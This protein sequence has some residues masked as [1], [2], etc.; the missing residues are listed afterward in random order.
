MFFIDALQQNMYLQRYFQCS[1]FAVLGLKTLHLPS[2]YRTFDSKDL[3]LMT[4]Q[5]DNFAS[6]LP[7]KTPWKTALVGSFQLL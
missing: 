1:F 6:L 4:R 3:N 5:C 7:E 2:K